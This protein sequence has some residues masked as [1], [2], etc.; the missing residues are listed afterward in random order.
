VKSDRGLH[1]EKVS[2]RA[3]DA[4]VAERHPPL[5]PRF[6]LRL[7]A[8]FAGCSLGLFAFSICLPESAFD[9]LNENAALM[10]AYCL[11]LVGMHPAVHGRILGRDGFSVAVA[12]E[13][14]TLYMCILFFSFVAASPA[15]LRKK[16]TGLPVGFAVLHVA[17]VLRIAAIFGIG[18]KSRSL[19]EIVHVY[20]GQVLMVLLVLAVCLY[21]LN[22]WGEPPTRNHELSSFFIRFIAF[23]CIPFLLWLPLNRQYLELAYQAAGSLFSLFGYQ[24]LITSHPAIDYHAF[25][26]VTFT[27]LVLAS[28]TRPPSR[29][30]AMLAAGH[31]VLFAALILRICCV[32]I[33]SFR[34]GPAD[35]AGAGIALCTQYILPVVL[36]LLLIPKKKDSEKLR[37]GQTA[38][39]RQ[40]LSETSG[41]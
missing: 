34:N 22:A 17:N 12:T 10:A 18:S 20:F 35:R 36:W 4:A 41:P 25:N 39:R 37:F 7:L 24:V 19:F 30:F 31:A 23:S 32:L 28:R 26:A 3:I 27:G 8:A 13:C 40:P 11:N 29:K 6:S 15:G 21:W 33:L 16:F 14:S 38:G 1:R 2:K 9:W 5:G